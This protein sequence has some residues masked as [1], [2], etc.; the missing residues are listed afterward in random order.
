MG[1]LLE[2]KVAPNSRTEEVVE[3]EPTVVRVKEPPREG[4]A[5]RAAVRLLSRHFGAPVR[6]VAGGRSRRK[7]VEIGQER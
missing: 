6:I 2:I 1:K 4:R 3:G 7:L 5:N